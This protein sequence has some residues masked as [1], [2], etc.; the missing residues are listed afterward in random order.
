MK[1]EVDRYTNLK[2]KQRF[3]IVNAK[4]LISKITRTLKYL[5][6]IIQD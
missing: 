5:K 4:I 1:F 6:V 2:Y 3:K